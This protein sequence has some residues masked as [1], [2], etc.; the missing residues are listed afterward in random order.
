M[1]F[2]VC[3]D[4]IMELLM[5]V[6]RM[7]KADELKGM[8]KERGMS[9]GGG[10][11]K[12]F[13]VKK[14]TIAFNKSVGLSGTKMVLEGLISK[15]ISIG[16]MPELCFSLAALRTLQGL[17]LIHMDYDRVETIALN[18]ETTVKYVEVHSSEM[19]K[20]YDA[21]ENEF[22]QIFSEGR[23][24]A[25]V[26]EL[27]SK[28]KITHLPP[29]GIKD[30]RHKGPP[31]LIQFEKMDHRLQKLIAQARRARTEKKGG[32]EKAAVDLTTG[33]DDIVFDDK[34]KNR[35]FTASFLTMSMR[36]E[37]LGKGKL[38]GSL[39][40]MIAHMDGSSDDKNA[41]RVDFKMMLE[42][43]KLLGC[44]EGFAFVVCL[45]F[46]RI[47]Y[48]RIFIRCFAMPHNFMGTCAS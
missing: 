36:E 10:K 44:P 32:I 29:S 5:E 38:K 42:N 19:S 27:S 40:A 30:D 1:R 37:D 24:N 11:R 21:L 45:K 39:K 46:L 23:M 15:R 20:D 25:L 9:T 14:L 17:F 22:P 43:V 35:K 33:E 28:G 47:M 34:D 2:V 6:Y 48:N 12:I 41:D 3:P 13:D 8:K 16:E 4:E 7:F 26:V 18:G 31:L